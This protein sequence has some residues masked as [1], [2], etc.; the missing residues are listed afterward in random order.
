MNQKV[1]LVVSKRHPDYVNVALEVSFPAVAP[2]P[3]ER[4]ERRPPK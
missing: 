3:E 4:L 2:K 1:P